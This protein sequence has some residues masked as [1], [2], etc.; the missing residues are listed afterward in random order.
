MAFLSEIFSMKLIV[1]FPVR[2]NKY[3]HTN[4][5]YQSIIALQ[6]WIFC[7]IE[8]TFSILNL[9]NVLETIKVDLKRNLE[10]PL[11]A[12]RFKNERLAYMP[13]MKIQYK[14]ETREK[15]PRSSRRKCSENAN[16]HICV[17]FICA[18][19]ENRWDPV[20]YLPPPLPP[21]PT[22]YSHFSLPPSAQVGLG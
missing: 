14:R 22:G 19:R 17:G 18:M 3:T 13:G 1:R 9:S 5:K 11:R 6:N 20:G 2:G 4:F 15:W 10:T 8:F 12:H 7:K 16:L 21:T